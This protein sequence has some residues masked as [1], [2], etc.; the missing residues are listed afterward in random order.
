MLLNKHD[1]LTV[2]KAIP[3]L[4][5]LQETDCVFEARECEIN[6]ITKMFQV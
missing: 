1:G 5:F 2:F 3:G 4:C 6:G